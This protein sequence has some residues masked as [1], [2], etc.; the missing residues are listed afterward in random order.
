MTKATIWDAHRR[1][2]I[3]GRVVQRGAAGLTI[4]DSV[5]VRLYATNDRII[6]EESSNEKL[7]TEEQSNSAE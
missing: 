1:N 5:G 6:E 3:T 4:E 2:Q 7:P